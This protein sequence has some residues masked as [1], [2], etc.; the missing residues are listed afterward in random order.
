[1]C[2]VMKQFNHLSCPY[3]LLRSGFLTT[4]KRLPARSFADGRRRRLSGLPLSVEAKRPE[5]IEKMHIFEPVRKA[6]IR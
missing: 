5:F 3:C 2:S 4:N 1:M 6:I